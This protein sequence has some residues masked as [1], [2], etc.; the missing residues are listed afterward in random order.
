MANKHPENLRL[1]LET[2]AFYIFAISGGIDSMSLLSLA[3][4]EKLRGKVVTVDHNLRAESRGDALF[5]K[6]EA[7]K[8]GYETEIISVDVKGEAER[9]GESEE[10]AARRL[11]HAAISEC[12]KKENAC[13]AVFAHHLGDQAETV[14]MRILRGTGV[15]GIKGMGDREGVFRPLLKYTSEEIKAYAAE[16]DV[17]Y[18]EDSTNGQS[19]YRR[20]FLRNVVFPRIAEVYPDF[21]RAF[22]RLAENAA[23]TEDYFAGALVQPE[24]DGATASFDITVLDGHPAVW[25]RSVRAALF[26]LGME[27]D[28]ERQTYD[29]VFALRN[30]NKASA[31]LGLGFAARTEYGKLIFER[32][33]EVQTFC[34]PFRAG[35][36]YEFCGKRYEFTE[37]DG[38]KKG[39]TMSKAVLNDDGLVVRT[40]RDGDS[41]KRYKGGRKSLSDYLTDVKMPQSERS[42]VLVLAKDSEIYAVLGVEVS[43]IAKVDGGEAIEVAVSEI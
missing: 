22:E 21:E 1:G 29:A 43:D 34:Q 3:A 5:V 25:K 31:D 10:L 12:V 8:L 23:E 33:S 14:L 7:A 28:V 42:K 4:K 20:N 19:V 32:K 41:F 2:D 35:A 26:G 17:P 37:A 6:A 39:V 27:K 30:R 11:R 36:S 16:N 24:S 38:I 9:S 13:G 40:R 18:R 15:A